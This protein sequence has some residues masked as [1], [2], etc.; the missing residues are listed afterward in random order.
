METKKK[1]VIFWITAGFILTIV[2]VFSALN[3]QKVDINFLFIKIEGR[4]FLLLIA[5]FLLGFFLGKISHML[6]KRKEKKERKR[7]DEYVAYL[8]EGRE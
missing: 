6:N 1:P 3:W 2:I 4:L 5:F 7:R 8:E